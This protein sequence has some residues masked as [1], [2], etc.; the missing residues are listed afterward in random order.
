ML[1]CSLINIMCVV[2]AE[3]SFFCCCRVVSVGFCLVRQ[4]PFLRRTSGFVVFCCGDVF[5]FSFMGYGFGI[6]V[7]TRPKTFVIAPT[8]GTT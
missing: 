4:E 6:V 5:F 8:L 1:C 2:V 7:G 3:Y